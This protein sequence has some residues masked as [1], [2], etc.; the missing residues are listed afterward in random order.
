MNFFSR[1]VCELG[2]D[3]GGATFLRWRMLP[4][5]VRRTN[6]PELRQDLPRRRGDLR[7]HRLAVEE[8]MLDFEAHIHPTLL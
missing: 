8:E 5:A 7:G 1:P 2:G 4:L 3:P 6:G